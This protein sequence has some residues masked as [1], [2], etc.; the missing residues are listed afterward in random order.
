MQSKDAYKLR[1]DW[2][3]KPC[4]HPEIGRLYDLG[5]HDGYVCLQCGKELPNREDF[6]TEGN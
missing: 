4:D 6:Y 2:G 3:N 5:V 1:E